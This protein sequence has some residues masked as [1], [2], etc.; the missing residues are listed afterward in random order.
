MKRKLEISV[1]YFINLQSK[2]RF[3]THCQYSLFLFFIHNNN[4]KPL[5]EMGVNIYFVSVSSFLTPSLVICNACAP[6]IQY[7]GLIYFHSYK[8]W[9]RISGWKK[10]VIPWENFTFHEFLEGLV[11]VRRV[12]KANFLETFYIL[13][14]NETVLVLCKKW[15]SKF[16]LNLYALSTDFGCIKKKWLQF[17]CYITDILR[18]FHF[19]MSKEK[20]KNI[21][22]F[23]SYSKFKKPL[24]FHF[25]WQYLRW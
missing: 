15:L 2:M 17:S 18:K 14:I 7:W 5:Q 24:N 3:I 9:K 11:A 16:S 6:D 23:K 22:Y 8:E 1:S 19:K 12:R 25:F 13:I 21:H 20:L 10:R 4:L